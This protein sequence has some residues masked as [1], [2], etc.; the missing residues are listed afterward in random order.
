[1]H[2]VGHWL[3]ISVSCSRLLDGGSLAWNSVTSLT[4]WHSGVFRILHSGHNS[5]KEWNTFSISVCS[6]ERVK[7]LGEKWI[8][9]VWN[10][11]NWVWWGSGYKP[12][13]TP[14]WGKIAI[15]RYLTLC[16]LVWRCH[17]SKT[18]L[19]SSAEYIIYPEDGL[20]SYR[21]ALWAG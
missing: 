21:T 1:V 8:V 11:F 9:K 20:L 14:L 2:Q 5:I 15:F 18:P 17:D 12:L 3:R 13:W 16:S 19:S 4:V 6:H 10:K 7:P